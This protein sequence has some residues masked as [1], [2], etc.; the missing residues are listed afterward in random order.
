[1]KWFCSALALILYAATAPGQQTAY[2]VVDVGPNRG[3]PWQVL[4]YDGNGANPEVFTNV[5]L[6]RPQ[7]IVFIEHQGVALVSNLGTGK[8][9]RYDATTGEYLDDFATGIGE[10]TRMEIGEDGLL[11]V[12]QWTGNGRV[13][14]YDL[15][16]NFVDEFTSTGVFNSIG[17]DWDDEGNLYVA[18]W[19]NG[20]GFGFVQRFDASGNDLGRF[21]NNNLTGPTNIWFTEDGGMN[22]VDWSA[23]MIRRFNANGTYLENLVTGLSEPEGVALLENGEF[24]L[25]NGGTSSVRR[26]DAEGNRLADFIT[27]AS[28]GLAK[29]NAIRKRVVSTFTINAGLNDAWFNS[30]TA[31]QGV[32]V[33][34]FP[35]LGKV[36]V[37]V[38]TFD[39][40]PPPEEATAVVGGPGQ[41]WFTAIGDYS[42]HQAT[43]QAELTA[44][45]LF[46]AAEPAPVQTPGYGT[47]TLAF[48]DCNSLV[49]TYELPGPELQGSMQLT[50]VV[51]DNIALCESLSEA[52]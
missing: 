40:T 49:L 6:N 31:G 46:D 12:L 11:Y 50:R 24:L 19:N 44:G 13:W 16:G 45:G 32:F 52:P 3:P 29:P 18:S 51:P 42:G 14:R 22:V 47:V 25:A 21:I 26:Y 39:A 28:G 20:N 5:E 43:L 23:N 15:D 8:I 41:R 33:N 27:F 36:F 1:M 37:A 17:M 34:V 9:T 7:D 35:G 2:Y 4:K 10:P 30:A 48:A 38:F